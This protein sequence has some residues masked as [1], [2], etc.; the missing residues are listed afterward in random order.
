MPRHR[1]LTI[2]AILYFAPLALVLPNLCIQPAIALQAPSSES[3]TV[4]PG[5]TPDATAANTA[6]STSVSGTTALSPTVGGQS[7]IEPSLDESEPGT[8]RFG[9]PGSGEAESS[10][11][12]SGEIGSGETGSDRGTSELCRHHPP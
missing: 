5:M 2:L 6:L 9:D 8:A 4:D 1:I 12:E 3:P 11:A 7:T 10:E